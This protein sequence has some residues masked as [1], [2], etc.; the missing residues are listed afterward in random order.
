MFSAPK[1]RRSTKNGIET[2]T[3]YQSRHKT[4]HTET[5]C[6]LRAEA[7]RGQADPLSDATLA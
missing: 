3:R 6:D 2:G 7:P 1:R 5:P 4:G